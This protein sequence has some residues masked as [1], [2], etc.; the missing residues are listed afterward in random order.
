MLLKH[1]SKSYSSLKINRESMNVTSN[2]NAIRASLPQAVKL[3]AVSKF[4]PIEAIQEAYNTGQ[5]I[6]GESRM[7]ELSQK[8]A[9]LP[10]DIEWHFI[11][12]LQSN[13]IKSIVPYVHTIHSIDSW[14][15]LEEIEKQAAQAQ[16]TINCLLEIHIAQEDSK[17]GLS[18]NDCLE[19]LSLNDWQNLQHIRIAG[20]MGMASNTDNEKT[21]RKEFRKL[22][23]FF[24]ELKNSSFKEKAYFTEISMG[25]SHDYQIAIEE[26]STMVR[27]GSSIFGDRT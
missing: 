8:Q 4:H 10:S 2:I 22:K 9:Q 3:V 23:T 1:R 6:F 20:L 27:V 24:N 16:R 18:E 11:G 7:Q 15:L 19:L 25:M 17:F 12:H 13:K 26:G 14:K 21:I 5:R